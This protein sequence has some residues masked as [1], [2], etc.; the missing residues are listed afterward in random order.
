MERKLD[1]DM[2][3]DDDDDNT[4][5]GPAPSSNA[6]LN[7]EGYATIEQTFGKGTGRRSF[8]VSKGVTLRQ[9]VEMSK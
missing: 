4:P 2:L 6:P 9:L 5:E 8:L 7:L 3:E 1:P